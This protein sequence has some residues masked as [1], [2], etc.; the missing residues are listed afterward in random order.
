[1]LASEHDTLRIKGADS[2]RSRWPL[3][4]LWVDLQQRIAELDTQGVWRVDG[5]AA[6]LR[7]QQQRL[8]IMVNG[9]VKR[10]AALWAARHGGEIPNGR[11][12]IAA[13]AGDLAEVHDPL[14]W[15]MDVTQRLKEIQLGP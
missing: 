2:N 15:Q 7:E 13:L 8:I 1:M 9:Y 12:A 3:H 14:T 11:R 10:Y 5:R 4:P 6:G